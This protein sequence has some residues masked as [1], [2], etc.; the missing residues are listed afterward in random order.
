[1]QTTEPRACSFTA[2]GF[3][4]LSLQAARRSRALCLTSLVRRDDMSQHLP[5]SVVVAY[6]VYAIFA[7]QQK[8]CIRDFKGASHAYYLLLGYFGFF[9]SVF[10][11]G[12]L[13]YYGFQTVWW[14]PLVLFALGLLVYI[15]SHPTGWLI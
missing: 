13:I 1:V 3:L 7:A 2:L 8:F 15:H 14:A 12:F 5:W 9:T 11:I 6:A 4:L 10:G